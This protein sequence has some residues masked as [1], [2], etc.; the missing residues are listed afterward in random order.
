[1]EYRRLGQSDLELSVLGLNLWETSS[2]WTQ[3]NDRDYTITL[4]QKAFELGI[5]FYG[6]ADTHG[7]RL[8][9][10]IVTKALKG[11]RH[12]VV[13]GT[14]FLCPVS[15]LDADGNLEN[16]R[17]W[18]PDSIRYSCEQSLLKMETDYIDL[19]QLYDPPMSIVMEDDLFGTLE[20]LT[21]EGKIRYWGIVMGRGA[22]A[23]NQAEYS[24]RYRRPCSM[25][26]E[27]SILHREQGRSI[28]P[29]AKDH[30][31]GLLARFP[32]DSVALPD[33]FPDGDA[34]SMADPRTGAQM[35]ISELND[36]KEKL[37]V[38]LRGYY[39]LT[40]READVLLALDQPVITSV[41]PEMGTLESLH[42]YTDVVDRKILGTEDLK[43]LSA[44]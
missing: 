26:I 16:R 29:I 6:A 17:N 44:F 19:Y 12:Q 37:A 43:Y 36:R 22:E 15:D 5:T 3:R 13:I 14:Q 30:L 25:E 7:Q 18:S 21:R 8:G 39:Q 10:E 1:M 38:H 31:I 11:L 34:M 41:L 24:M 2:K 4:L 28:F 20:D 27:Y 23:Y 40:T 9:E 33:G 32:D 42:Q 35:K